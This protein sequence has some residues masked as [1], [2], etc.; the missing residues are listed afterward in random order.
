MS[1]ATNN[2]KAMSL[3][4]L[5]SQLKDELADLRKLKPYEDA[6]DQGW[7][8][9]YQYVINLINIIVKVNLRN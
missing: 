8:E 2:I 1:D 4:T 7:D 6:T 5:L 9:C 3:D